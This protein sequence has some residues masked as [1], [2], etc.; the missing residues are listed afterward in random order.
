LIVFSSVTN[1]CLCL[2]TQGA[3]PEAHVVVTLSSDDNNVL[4]PKPDAPTDQKGLAGEDAGDNGATLAEP[5]A[6][7][8]ISSA[9]PEQSKPS[10]TD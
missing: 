3:Y 1:I 7:G 6:P 10:A 2:R 8:L 9:M 5:I 4:M